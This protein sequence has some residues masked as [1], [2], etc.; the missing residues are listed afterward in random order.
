MTA[1]KRA[2]SLS[3]LALAGLVLWWCV[4]VGPL[5]DPEAALADFHTARNR[6]EDQLTDPLVLAGPGVRPLVLAAIRDPESPRRRY[7]IGFLGCAGYERAASAL[8]EIIADGEEKNYYRADALVAL[9]QLDP[10]EGLHLAKVYARQSDF[11]GETARRIV[12][13]RPLI[14]CRSWLDAWLGRHDHGV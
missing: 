4:A 6:A 1:L 12:A 14:Y 5:R 9:W 10:T 13:G 2:L 3:L 7:A 11:L 8:R